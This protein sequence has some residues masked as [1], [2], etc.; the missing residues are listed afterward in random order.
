MRNHALV[1]LRAAGCL[2]EAC[3]EIEMIFHECGNAF[4]FSDVAVKL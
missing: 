2:C 4:S 3:F 1:T